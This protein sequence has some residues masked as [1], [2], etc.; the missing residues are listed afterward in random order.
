M[1]RQTAIFTAGIVLLSIL[2][3]IVVKTSFFQETS[4]SNNMML[5]DLQNQ[6]LFLDTYSTKGDWNE[7]SLKDF[8]EEELSGIEKAQNV[9]IATPTNNIFCNRAVI[10]QEVRVVENKKGKC[11]EKTIWMVS[12]GSTV[13]REKDG[14]LTLMGIDYSLMQTG[15]NYLVFCYPFESKAYSDKKVY[16]L[17][18][19]FWFPYYNLTRDSLRVMPDKLY[20][21]DIEFYA[22][23]KEILEAFQELKKKI[24]KHYHC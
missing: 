24:R 21:K 4:I 7:E 16:F 15:C 10:M 3:A 5:D 11:K 1:K 12:K 17:D 14:N 20:H 2:A 19:S 9:M 6:K 8:V 13:K 23:T 22:E 18:D